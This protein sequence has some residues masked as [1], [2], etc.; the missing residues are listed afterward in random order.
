MFLV[1]CCLGCSCFFGCLQE[2]VDAVNSLGGGTIKILA[3]IYYMDSTCTLSSG[4]F[5]EGVGQGYT[6]SF[7]QYGT[8]LILSD[9]AD[10]D[11]FDCAGELGSGFTFTF[12]VSNIFFDGNRDGQSGDYDVMDF[13]D[14]QLLTV[15]KCAVFDS[16]QFGLVARRARITNNWFSGCGDS[17]IYSVTDNMISNNEI[18]GCVADSDYEGNGQVQSPNG[19]DVICNNVIYQS[20][21]GY[22]INCYGAEVNII[23]DNRIDG[24]YL[25]GIYLGGKGNHTVCGNE[26]LGNSQRSLGYHSGIRVN[27]DSFD[28]ISFNRITNLD[29][30]DNYQKYGINEYG[31]SDYNSYIGNVVIGNQYD[32]IITIGANSQAHLFY[33]GTGNWVS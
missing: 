16:G 30:F 12:G 10:C 33:N 21:Y 24:N 28:V 18:G 19:A 13:T 9:G 27:G 32:Y 8:N 20:F 15:D 7:H 14:G 26:I 22:G 29:S 5:L 23:S 17:G 25:G 4:V 3:G 6:G 31:S 11:M 1:S 2:C